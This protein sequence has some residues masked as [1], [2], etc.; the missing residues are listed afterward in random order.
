MEKRSI[1]ANF[2]YN[3]C[4]QIL[5]I[6]L[7]LITAPYVS[8]VLGANNVGMYSYSQAIANY[9]YL[10]GLLGVN[11]YGNRTIAKIRD[12]EQN[13]S[14]IFWEIFSFQ[15]MMGI[16]VSS[17]YM[18]YVMIFVDQNKIVYYVQILYVLSSALDV[19]WFCFGIENFKLTTIRSMLVRIGT[20]CAVFMFVNSRNDLAIY[21]FILSFSNILSA[22]VIWP[23]VIKRVKFVRPSLS[24]IR[25]HIKQNL[26]LF[27]PILAVSL[28][29]IMDKLMLGVFAEKQ[30]VGFYTYAERITQIPYTIMLAL[31]NVMMP[32]MSNLYAKND[33]KQTK[34]MMDNV[35]LFA[36]FMSAALS[37]GLAA[38]APV[39]APWFYGAEF[40]RC[41]LFIT[42]LCPT[43][44]F[45]GWAGVL[46]TQYIIPTGKD[47]V[48]IISLFSGAAVNL[49]L[50]FILL[51]RYAGIG[52]IIGT[53]GAEF[54]VFAVQFY[55]CRKDIPLKEYMGDG[56]RFSM[57]G[58]I[59]YC[60]V[61][62]LASVSNNTIITMAIQIIVGVFIYVF[63]S[64][65]YM[66]KIK[67]NPVFVNEG[68]KILHINKKF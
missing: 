30:E 44:L 18:G 5:I 57:I 68:L 54:T 49:G 60:V 26:I 6:I 38:V 7:P 53:I 27:L 42:L 32:R 64:G 63:L 47:R 43:I 8:R 20:A 4:Y 11:N 66:I 59:M 19:N 41:G 37:F 61:T 17:C 55:M 50:N 23:F 14:R 36:M 67:K 24:R 21:A 13:M 56:V 58:L 39:F 1:K 9:F 45:K 2:I 15:F 16:I 40:T 12:N 10:F 46:R 31:D 48:F 25:E 35:M 29:N 34:Y 65:Y 28:Y 33:T 3:I 52:A 51:P 22:L 62:A